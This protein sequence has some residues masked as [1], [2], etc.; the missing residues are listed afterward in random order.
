M[1]FAKNII[2]GV[3]S[4]FLIISLSLSIMSTVFSLTINEKTLKN[5]LENSIK[6]YVEQQ[7]DQVFV[8]FTGPLLDAEH[9]YALSICTVEDNY[10]ISEL[11][12]ETLSIECDKI[13]GSTPQQFLNYMKQEFVD[14]TMKEVNSSFED[15]SKNLVYATYS[16]ITSSITSLLLITIIIL[17]AWGFPFKLFGTSAMIAGSPAIVLPIIQPL[18][19]SLINQEIQKNLSPEIISQLSDSSLIADVSK[20]ISDLFSGM[21]IGFAIL[22]S[23]GLILLIIGFLIKMKKPQE[24]SQP[25]QFTQSPPLLERPQQYPRPVQRQMALQNFPGR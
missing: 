10:I 3:L 12:N 16:S 19:A 20:I 23:V 4:L 1:G 9:R 14:Y 21:I 6:P 7:V 18:I 24:Y 8:N 13:L 2:L 22:F 25:K 15:S 5:L 11:K 17:V